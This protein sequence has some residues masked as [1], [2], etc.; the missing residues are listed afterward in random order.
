MHTLSLKLNRCFEVILLSALQ[1]LKMF[2]TTITSLWE[3]H[4]D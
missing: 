3:T 2:H 1:G 4:P